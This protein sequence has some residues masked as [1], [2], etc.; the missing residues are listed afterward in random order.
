M[1]VDYVLEERPAVI[2]VRLRG[3][4]DAYLR[5]FTPEI[6]KQ[7]RTKPRHLVAN[8]EE[9]DFIGSRGMGLLFHLHKVLSDIGRSLVLAAPSRA[10]T[11]ALEIGGI[12]SLLTIASSE[13]AA[14]AKVG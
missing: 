5:D 8:L 11:D 2:I 12:E 3:S 7:I 1:K 14:L 13:A 4:L 9:I 10:V 6:E